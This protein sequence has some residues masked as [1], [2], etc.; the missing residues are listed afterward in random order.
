MQKRSTP[1]DKE[2]ALSCNLDLNTLDFSLQT[3]GEFLRHVRSARQVSIRDFEDSIGKTRVYIS[4]IERGKN[5]PPDKELLDLMILKLN[6]K[7]YPRVVNR[8]Y[9]LAAIERNT[10]PDDLKDWIM[11]DAGHREFLRKCR[12]RKLTSAQIKKITKIVEEM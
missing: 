4:D 12:D 11:A 7:D 8:L 10:V 1:L 6:I 5:K 3:F 9:D 2:L